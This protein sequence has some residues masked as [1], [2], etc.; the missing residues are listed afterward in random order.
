MS[1]LAKQ[2]GVATPGIDAVIQ[3]ASIV[4]ASDY[5][6]AAF[7]TPASLGIADRSAAELASL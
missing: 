4:M 1:E 2:V 6:A 3:V 5:R 7:R